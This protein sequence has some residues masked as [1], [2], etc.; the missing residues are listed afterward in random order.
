M[1]KFSTRYHTTLG[2]HSHQ[3]DEINA[4]QRKTGLTIS[5]HEEAGELEEWKRF[6]PFLRDPGSLG[7]VN[8]LLFEYPD[9]LMPPVCADISHRSEEL[10]NLFQS[11]GGEGLYDTTEDDVMT[12]FNSHFNSTS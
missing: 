1:E 10:E 7:M 5:A 11:V 2:Q 12:K 8:S 6:K 4:L 3:W 9:D